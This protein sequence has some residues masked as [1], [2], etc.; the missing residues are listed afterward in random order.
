LYAFVDRPVTSL[1]MGCR[2]L[3]WS[4]RSWVAVV[5]GRT[6]PGPALAP[7]F[8]KWRMIAGLRPFLR[9]MLALDRGGLQDMQFCSLDC[10]RI[11]E[12][13]AVLLSVFTALAGDDPATA[14]DTL[15]LLI[16]PDSLGD[17]FGAAAEM[18]RALHD[19]SIAPCEPCESRTQR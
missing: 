17:C 13:E 18:T 3:I 15:S 11:G 5:R 19:A 8:A 4:M 14:R 7:A 2:F 6:C 10:N 12:H 1:D 9:L 16:E